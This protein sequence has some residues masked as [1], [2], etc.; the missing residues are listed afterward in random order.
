MATPNTFLSNGLSGNV[1][2][3]I[4]HYVKKNDVKKK[5]S[6]IQCTRV[7][8][9]LVCPFIATLEG[10]AFISMCSSSLPVQLCSQEHLL[11]LEFSVRNPEN[12]EFANQEGCLKSLK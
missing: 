7:L 1:V 10:D 11:E 5:S 6:L 12:A 8:M 3:H 2:A 4:D 9:P